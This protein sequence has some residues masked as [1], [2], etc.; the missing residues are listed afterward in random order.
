MSYYT[1]MI[2]DMNIAELADAAGVSRR[3]VRFYVQEKLLEPPEG[4]GR[5]SHYGPGHLAQLRQIAEWQRAGHSLE[6]MRRLLRGDAVPAPVPPRPAQ[7]GT[8][9]ARLLSRVELME[10]VELT[11]DA[12]RLA[13]DGEGLRALSALAREVFGP[14]RA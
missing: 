5:G 12:T 9:A 3:A 7:E 8:M 2:S 4:A 1:V 6:A 11:Y 10:G 13:P 14:R